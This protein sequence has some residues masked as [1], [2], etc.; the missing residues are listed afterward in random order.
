MRVA[1]D[2]LW[3]GASHGLSVLEHG[4][5]RRV[6]LPAACATNEVRRLCLGTQGELW[7][8]LKTGDLLRLR[9]PQDRPA[10]IEHLH[11]FASPINAL[12]VDAAERL[13]CGTQ[14][15]AFL[16]EEDRLC[17]QWTVADGLPSAAIQA[18][19]S[20]ATGCLWAATDA[21]L[22]QLV[23]PAA[24]ARA[25]ARQAALREMPWAFAEHDAD[26]VWV[27]TWAGLT[28]RSKE[29]GVAIP[30]PDLPDDL[31]TR[32]VWALCRDQRGALWA[33][34]RRVGLFCLD[35]DSGAPYAHLLADR[36]VG[37][38][39]LFVSS[40]G[41]IWVAS[42]R[43][44]VFRVDAVTRKVV[45]EIGR[46]AGMPDVA[47]RGSL[48]TGSSASGSVPRRAG[49]SAWIPPVIQ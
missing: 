24:P 10:C 34:V 36:D 22:A 39:A 43:E 11:H 37:I 40:T 38:P 23:S 9:R 4:V 20:D 27:G 15:G 35:P 19:L 42:D 30:R 14:E 17:D 8:G 16:I 12:H 49:S 25:V 41:D 46:T 26:H 13:W 45:A 29:T 32:T 33:G 28:L 47:V 48:L 21:G 31:Q 2:Q 18:L 3:I 5:V 6:S 44:G 1:S 7:I